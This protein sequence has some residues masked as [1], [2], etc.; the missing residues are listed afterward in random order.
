VT[1]EYLTVA[2]LAGRLKLTSKTV[3]N[4]MYSGTWKKGVHWFAP[5][6]TSPRFRWST[7]V[8]WIETPDDQAADQGAA[9][10]GDVPIPV[11]GRRRVRDVA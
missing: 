9:Y 6:G 8:A 3:R 11:R 4:R 10:D 7:I 1:D 5:H 2:E